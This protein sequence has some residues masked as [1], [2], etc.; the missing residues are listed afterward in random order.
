MFKN[1]LF[2]KIFTSYIV[3]LCLC[4]ALTGYFVNRVLREYYLNPLTRTLES[5]MKTIV[6]YMLLTFA[7]TLIISFIL[8]RIN[9]S[10]L[11]N[12]TQIAKNFARGNFARKAEIASSDEMGDLAQ[13]INV[14]G[15]E[16]Q[17]RMQTILDD[18]NKLDAIMANMNDAVIAT[19]LQE[20]IIL[21]NNAAKTMFDISAV[22]LNKNYLWEKVRNEKLRNLV[23]ETIKTQTARISEIE[24]PA[25]G[26]KLLHTH[27][28]PIQVDKDNQGVLLVFHDITELRKLENARREFVANVSH[29]LR[30][31]LASI[32]GYV[33]TLLENNSLRQ[34][35]TQEFLHIIMKHS[36]RLDSLIKDIL[37]LSRLESQDLQTELTPLDIHP[38][39]EHI[40]SQYHEHCMRKNQVLDLAISQQIPL[41]ETNNY[42]LRQLL[43]NLLDNAVKY[44]AKG[45]RIG[46]K[47]EPVNQSIRIEISDT[48]CGIPQEHI[49][50]IFERFY[51]VD[52]ARSREM[53]GTGLGLSIVKHIVLIHH[54]HIQVESAVN[55]G[56]KFIITVPLQQPKYIA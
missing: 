38:C 20:R 3:L 39:I 35:D 5:D 49:P 34:E 8:I 15:V 24:I 29:E 11:V 31:P 54:G 45:G 19:D 6:G 28:S 52:P 14:M 43:T 44:T 55:V 50:R 48:G 41:I 13:A 47:V 16:L 21:I 12:I 10:S 32:K 40:S 51:R 9:T 23:R 53:G 18:K 26:K 56:T 36:Q 27:L 2:W 22:V 4:L 7:I 30:T 1:K 37:E 17:S 33:E 46:L 42:L 25:P